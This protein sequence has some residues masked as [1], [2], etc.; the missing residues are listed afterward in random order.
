MG[1]VSASLQRAPS[2]TITYHSAKIRAQVNKTVKFIDSKKHLIKKAVA[3]GSAS[4]K[5]ARRV[6]KELLV[7]LEK[8]QAA[9]IHAREKC[10]RSKL[11]RR[12]TK[13]LKTGG[14]CG[15]EFPGLEDGERQTLDN[16]LSGACDG[17]NVAHLWLEDNNETVL[18]QGH[19]ESHVFK[20]TK[21]EYIVAYWN[22]KEGET[23]E[24]AVDFTS[25]PSNLQLTSTT[26]SSL[27]SM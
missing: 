5:I 4:T 14:G 6:Q 8:R 22:E 23:Y 10:E 26:T 7:E 17:L 16:I 18:Y 3:K 9:K 25:L 13:V 15:E 27:C 12:F 21:W 20:K 1:M 2:A 19:I 24:D 11:E